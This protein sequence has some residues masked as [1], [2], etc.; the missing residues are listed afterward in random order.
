MRKNKINSLKEAV[1]STEDLSTYLEQKASNHNN[2]KAY[3]DVTK[4][5][6][7]IDHSAIYLS[8]GKNWNDRFDRMRFNKST[9]EVVNYGMCFSFSRSENVAMWM[10]YGGKGKDGA[11][12][13]FSRANITR[14]LETNSVCLGSWKKGEFEEAATLKRN[15]FTVRIVDVLY[16]TKN[17]EGKYD[18]KRSDESVGNVSKE[19]IDTL[20]QVKKSYAWNYENECRLI[21]TIKKELIP[22][23]VHTLRIDVGNAYT[24]LLKSNRIYRAPNNQTAKE[25]VESKLAFEIDWDLCYQC[26]CKDNKRKNEKRK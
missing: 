23:G 25:F 26:N 16:F 17:M 24:E 5:K 11:M 9:S 1:T 6:Y 19:R 7:W 8:D 20:N 22:K 4:V 15:E 10:L 13:D 18:I 2:Y 12:V 3:S 21:V 14:M